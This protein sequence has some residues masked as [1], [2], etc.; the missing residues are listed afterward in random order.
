MMGGSETVSGDKDGVHTTSIHVPI[1][2]QRRVEGGQVI[3]ISPS[4]TTLSSLDEVKTYL[5]TDSTCK[6]GLECP[7]I[8]HKVFNFT[9]AAKVEQYSHPLGKAEQDMTK[10]CNHRRKVVAMAALCR[11]MQASQLPFTNLHHPEANSRVDS[12]DPKGVL[13]EQEEEDR[14]VYHAK[15][16]PAP[17]RPH[18]NLHS[19]PCVSPK[20]SHQFF[21]PYNGSSPVLHT[22]TNSHH[23]LDTLRRHHH[24]PPLPLS[25]PSSSNPSVP[26]Y[27]AAQR[28]PCIPTPQNVSHGQRT[29]KTPE[30]LGSPRLRPL[31]SPPPSSPVTLGGGGRGAQTH[32]HHPH[33]VI[34][35]GSPLSPS[36]SLSPSV[37]NMNSL[38]PH[39]RSRHPSA[40]P[41]PFSEQGGSST[42]AEGGVLMGS[43]LSQRRKSSSSSPHSPL[44]SGSPN[45]SPHFHKYKLEEIL[46]QFKNSG[47]SSTNNHHLN[48]INPTLLTN[49]NSSNSH[50]L[51]LKSIMSPASAAG[52]PGFGLN[53]TCPSSL[54]L[55]PFP[56]QHS[57]QGKLPHPVPFPASSLLSAA[58][59]AQ[60][61][62]QITPGQSSNAASS[63]VNLPSSLEVLK[64]VQ[65]QQQQSSKVTNSTLHNSHPPPYIASAR[66]PHS[67]LTAASAVL[68]PPSYSLAQS[69][70][71]SLPHLPPAAER[72]ASHRK[73]QRRS[74]TVLSM[75]RDPQ[76]L[77]NGPQKT[78]PGDTVSATVINLSSASSTSHSSSTSPVQ[79][80]TAVILENHHHHLLPGQMLRLSAPRQAAHLSRP[81]RQNEALDFTTGLTP[82][83][84]GLD[85]PTQP[86]SALLHLLSVQNAQATASASNSASAVSVEGGGHTN[87][88]SPRLS[89]CSPTSHSNIRHPQTQSPCQ[90]NDT[91]FLPSVSQPLS[92]PPTSSPFRTVQCHSHSRP[93]K[94]SPLQRH[95]P[96][97]AVMPNSNLALQNSSSPSQQMSPTP[98]DKQQPSENHFPTVDSLSQAPLREAPGTVTV[99]MGVNSI[100]SGSVDLSNSQGSVSLAIA[101][102]PKPLDLSNHVLAILAASSSVPQGED[103]PSD[104]TTDAEMSS[105]GNHTA[106]PEDPGCVKVSTVTKSP[107]ATSPGPTVSSHVVDIS[108][109]PSVVGDSTTPLTLAEAFPFMNQEQ[110]LQLLSSTG[111]L[112]SLLDP[113]VLASLPLGGLWLGGQHA[114]I[115][116]A[117]A[118]PHHLSEPQPPEQQQLLIQQQ[119]TQQQHQDHQQRQ[120]QINNPL[121]PL[122]PLLSGAQG[123]LPLN[124]LGLLNPLPS[125]ATTPT[126]GQDSDL[127]LTE[128]P[129]LQAL[130]MASLLLGQHQAPLLPLS[131]LGHL[132]QVS[133]EVPLQQPQQIPTTLEG[134]TLDKTS[135]LLDPSTLQS[136]GLVEV[137]QGLLSIPPGAEGSVQALQSLLLPAA[138]PP[139][140][141]AFLSLSPALLSAALSSAELHSPPHTQSVPAQQTQHTQPQVSA[142]A[143]V[144]TLIPL[145]IQAKDSPILQHLLPTL[146]NPAVLGDLSGIT[147]LHNMMGIGAGS[148]LLP[149]VQTSALG[150]PLLQGP[151]GAINLLNNLQL[152]LTPPSE[153]EKPVSLQ[154]TQSPT[155]EE[156]I[157]AGQI[158]PVGPSPPPAPLTAQQP[159]PAP[160]RGS[161]GRSIIDPY[162]SFMDTIY[163]S[164]LQVSA[165][166]QEDGAH[167]GPSDPT[168]PFCA[169]PPVSF[170]VEHHT[171]ST[172]V[173]TL[174]Q[175]SAPVSLSPRRACSLRNPD[176]S[177]LS[178][179]AAAHSPA[180]GTPKP[181]E[182]GST[183]PLQRKPVMVEGH[184]HPEPPLPP[185]YLEE[186]KTDCTGPAAAVCPFVEAG[187]DRQGHLPHSGYLSP[188][189][190]CSGRSS[191]ETVGTL[192]HSEHGRDQ[193]GATGG[194]RRGRK[195]KQTLQ[196][197]LEDFRDLDAAALEETKATTALLKPERSVRGRRRRGTRSQRQ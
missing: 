66:P 44:P 26:P 20:S 173:S 95:S 185:I 6:C 80:Q 189:D 85:P 128:K 159:T 129:S 78:P 82:T 73:R 36:P 31:S 115:P 153:A 105:Q 112:P 14:G 164:F 184:T 10:L 141:A 119:E 100:S 187:G 99:E 193:A 50:G 111:G 86:L 150:M 93:T 139:P 114:Q 58:A 142:D 47:N 103:S 138:L 77:A 175:A 41:S 32:V 70:A 94:S 135:G 188:R 101:T 63:P 140:H 74:P 97:S 130:L 158:A 54:P 33:G 42:A 137:A 151:D 56:N 3:Y 51:S 68:L 83:P 157:P 76:Q 126:P 72:N 60:L 194:A 152:N 171:P 117:N 92:P 124:L 84:V 30:T 109:T 46:E 195:R 113:A 154:E 108:S 49:Q 148:I 174:P 88:Q 186:A 165:K 155:P 183:S 102:S 118:T 7:L 55:G 167:L 180:Q 81:S 196:N 123:E 21:Y 2:W 147:G 90:T 178:L 75:L 13:M 43:N 12:R 107:E 28:S 168:S 48:P 79:N 182:D 143:G 125:P 59:K 162:T 136:T 67:S 25:S 177:R 106:G 52:P 18:N 192:M 131:G 91:N 65:Q 38:S 19:N 181:T 179:E 149:P 122:L 39:Q 5:L 144:D 45:P 23:P 191:E 160:Q 64:E 170:P 110:L 169:L 37:H 1:G 71:S 35:G 163:T 22:G 89:P 197:V 134:L 121:F 87:K 166:E 161:E 62:N 11:S 57:H 69:L 96:T 172:P 120:Q 145:S 24:P 116:P 176:L 29:A 156:D 8:I 15:L 127:A 190:G 40:S 98:S 27:S 53:S 133:L 132:S 34:V 17:A 61:A 4:G 16:H 9:M 104:G 146:L